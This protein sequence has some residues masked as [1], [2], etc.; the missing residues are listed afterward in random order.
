EEPDDLAG[1]D[2][3][4]DAVD[5]GAAIVD[6]H[7]TVGIEEIV[8]ARGAREGGVALEMEVGFVCRGT[9]TDGRNGSF[10][11]CGG[12]RCLGFLGAGR[13]W[14]RFFGNGFGGRRLRSWGG[15]RLVLDR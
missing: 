1:A 5:D 3:D 13:R 7:E 15:H 9:G 4:V 6:F 2:V 10:G 12:G 11:K 14:F 8:V